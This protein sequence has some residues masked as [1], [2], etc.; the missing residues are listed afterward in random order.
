M[1]WNYI[2]VGSWHADRAICQDH[3]IY[4]LGKIVTHLITTPPDLLKF[5]P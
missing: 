2:M 4:S 3:F 1:I 5:E